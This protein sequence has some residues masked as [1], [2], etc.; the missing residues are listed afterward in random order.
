MN[1]GQELVPNFN[2][3]VLWRLSILAITSAVYVCNAVVKSSPY[4][5]IEDKT[6]C[7]LILEL[8]QITLIKLMYSFYFLRKALV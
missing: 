8:E 4:S 1:T 7:W 2:R 6:T 5:Q 3:H